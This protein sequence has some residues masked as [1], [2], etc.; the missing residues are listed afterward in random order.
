MKRKLEPEKNLQAVLK[1]KKNHPEL[2]AQRSA[3]YNKKHY[4]KI[5][6]YRKWLTDAQ[7]DP[8]LFI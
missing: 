6:L 1:W 2:Y 8:T 4:E 7:F 5:R 3:M